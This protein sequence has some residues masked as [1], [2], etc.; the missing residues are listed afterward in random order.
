MQK[1]LFA[2]FRAAAIDLIYSIRKGQ[3][4]SAGVMNFPDKT[5]QNVSKK[6]A[7]ISKT[8]F[9]AE[10]YILFSHG[11]SRSSEALA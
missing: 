4:F 8:L 6:Y 2:P 3:I 7:F 1:K 9:S 5:M 11:R 10:M